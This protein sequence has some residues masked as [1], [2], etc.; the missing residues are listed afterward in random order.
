MPNRSLLRKKRSTRRSNHRCSPK[1]KKHSIRRSAKRS[2]RRSRRSFDRS[3][4]VVDNN[5]TDFNTL[6]GWLSK[7]S[8]EHQKMFY[9]CVKLNECDS[10]VHNAVLA[11]NQ[12]IEEDAKKVAEEEKLKKM[13]L[14]KE[15]DEK[16][17]KCNELNA[18]KNGQTQ[19]I[20]ELQ[21]NIQGLQTQIS[22]LQTQHDIVN[23]GLEKTNQELLSCQP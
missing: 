1:C 18:L 20:Q 22:D 12:Q 21:K 17:A 9:D 16:I 6:Q 5:I 13:A 14:Q 4:A 23:H 15:L 19:K 10:K 11:F 3:S 2:S 8:A 7:L